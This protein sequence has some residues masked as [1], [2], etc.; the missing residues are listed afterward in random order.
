M[1]WHLYPAS[2]HRP[3]M[4]PYPKFLY[5]LV[6][7]DHTRFVPWAME[8]YQTPSQEHILHGITPIF[9][10]IPRIWY[11]TLSQI[12]IPIGILRPWNHTKP[13]PRNSYHMVWHLYPEPYHE[14]GIIPSPCWIIPNLIPGTHTRWYD[15]HI[16]HTNCGLGSYQS[17]TIG[18]Y[19]SIPGPISHL[20]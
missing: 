6:C 13:H 3:G 11:N 14:V 16:H 7:W 4:I 12:S 9:N 15:T 10:T 2:Y 17:H 8:L 20:K 18:Y 19:R 5:Q 1:V